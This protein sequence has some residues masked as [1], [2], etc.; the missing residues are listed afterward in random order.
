M[1]NKKFLAAYDDYLSILTKAGKGATHDYRRSV[2]VDFLRAAFDVDV[3]EI[4]IEEKLR[5]A[6]VRG[7]IDALYNAVIFEFKKDLRKERE[8]AMVELRKY[9]IARPEVSIALLTEGWT[10]EVYVPDSA[11]PRKVHQLTLKPDNAD[12][13]HL[14]FDSYL[15]Q[16]TDLHPTSDD[17]V[18]RFGAASPTYLA[19]ASQLDELWQKV[20]DK[21]VTRVKWQEWNRLL[22][23]VYGVAVGSDDLFLRHTYLSILARWSKP[24]NLRRL[25]TT[26][27]ILLPFIFP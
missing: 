23:K 7:F 9:F 1:P 27:T 5:V 15:F 3:S 17:V 26:S 16:D 22:A 6:E 20:G 18:M 11:G 2:F 14:F 13:A 12:E 24:T 19:F 25:P 8:D 4:E 21:P 10:F